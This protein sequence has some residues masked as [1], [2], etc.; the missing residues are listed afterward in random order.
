MFQKRAGHCRHTALGKF[1]MG[2]GV[3]VTLLTFTG[4]WK[5]GC[6]LHACMLAGIVRAVSHSS[7]AFKASRVAR[8]VMTPDWSGLNPKVSQ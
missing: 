6:G 2:E 4:Q 1:R 5:P 7:P 8:Q 3:E